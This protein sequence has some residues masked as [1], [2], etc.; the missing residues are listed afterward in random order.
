V[1]R[2]VNLYRIARAQAGQNKGALA[3]LLALYSGGTADEIGTL[4]R[5]LSWR[6]DNAPLDLSG[7]GARLAQALEAAQTADGLVTVASA[8]RSAAIAR[9][10]STG[11]AP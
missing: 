9:T 4:R 8:R 1:K 3:L 7:G 2:F 11:A 5:A 6:D 10:F